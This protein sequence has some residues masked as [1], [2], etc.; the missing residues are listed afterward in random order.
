MERQRQ[1]QRRKEL[2]QQRERERQQMSKQM[3]KMKEL[4]N[5]ITQMNSS[6]RSMIDSLSQTMGYLNSLEE[7]FMKLKQDANK[8]QAM[9]KDM[10]TNIT[11]I[12]STYV[13]KITS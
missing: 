5:E 1:I 11:R 6:S 10:Y 9:N 12:E 3:Q 7:Q 13:N 4:K 2:Q 8:L